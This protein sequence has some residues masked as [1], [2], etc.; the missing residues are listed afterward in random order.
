MIFQ[1]LRENGPSRS[2]LIVAALEQTGIPAAT[3]RQ[4]VARVRPPIRRFPVDL[5]PRREAFVY[6]EEQRSTER[7]WSNLMRDMRETGSVYG[8]ATDALLARGGRCFD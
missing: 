1:F 2:S 5:L 8:A 4:Q 3:A 7:F 6:L